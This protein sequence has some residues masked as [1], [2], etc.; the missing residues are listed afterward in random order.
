MQ[1]GPM[2][3]LD[4]GYWVGLAMGVPIG[5]ALRVIVAAIARTWR[6]LWTG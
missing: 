3:I 5:F 2:M 6:E 1:R 4:S